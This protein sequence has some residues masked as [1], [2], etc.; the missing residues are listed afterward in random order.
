MT[1]VG[2]TY[3]KETIRADPLNLLKKYRGGYNVTNDHYWSVSI[4]IAIAPTLFILTE[5][6]KLTSF[7]SI[8]S[9]VQSTAFTGIPGYAVALI[10]LLCGIGYGILLLVRTDCFRTS[11]KRK[12]K[13]SCYEQ[14]HLQPII[15]ASFCTLLAV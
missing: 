10:W 7:Y 3:M 12:N 5:N 13:S 2:M 11:R 6:E 8:C 9:V 14:Y 15:L 1:S 4:G